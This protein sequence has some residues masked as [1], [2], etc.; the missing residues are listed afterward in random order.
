MVFF[1]SF[2][3]YFISLRLKCTHISLNL[4]REGLVVVIEVFMTYHTTKLSNNCFL[5][6]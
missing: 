4:S 6:I 2:T 5:Y 1:F 3:Y